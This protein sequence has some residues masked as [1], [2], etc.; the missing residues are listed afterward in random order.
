MG[1]CPRTSQISVHEQRDLLALGALFP[2]HSLWRSSREMHSC[3]VQNESVSLPYHT[4]AG[5]TAKRGLPRKKTKNASINDQNFTLNHK[6][7]PGLL[8]EPLQHLINVY[9]LVFSRMDNGKANKQTSGKQEKNKRQQEWKRK[10][11]KINEKKTTSEDKKKTRQSLD[12]CCWGTQQ[13]NQLL[14]ALTTVTSGV[15]SQRSLQFE[16][17]K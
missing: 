15:P 3:V 14:R 11:K 8:D 4:P 5:S 6:L 2:Q 17:R 7:A 10:N 9:D 13:T 12:K 16:R 1:V